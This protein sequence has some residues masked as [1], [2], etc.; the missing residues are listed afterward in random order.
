MVGTLP[1]WF[2]LNRPPPAPEAAAIFAETDIVDEVVGCVRELP[3]GELGGQAGGGGCGRVCRVRELCPRVQGGDG[4]IRRVG[5]A[6]SRWVAGRVQSRKGPRTWMAWK[7][8]SE[9]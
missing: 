9:S 3:A 2:R 1:D 4:G 5:E 8:Q 6:R 7:G